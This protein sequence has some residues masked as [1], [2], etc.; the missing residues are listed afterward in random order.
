MLESLTAARHSLF[1]GTIVN[2]E[3]LNTK[4]ERAVSVVPAMVDT[5]ARGKRDGDGEEDAES[6]ASDPTELFHRDIG[7]QT[8]PDIDTSESAEEAATVAPVEEHSEKLSSIRRHLGDLSGTGQESLEA[9]EETRSSLGNLQAYLEELAYGGAKGA[10][11][12]EGGFGPL[13]EPMSSAAPGRGGA[14]SMDEIARFKADIRSVK[15]VLLSA[16]NFPTG[17]L[18]RGWG[19]V[20]VAS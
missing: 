19:G 2:L 10:L 17:G 3:T 14:G 18:G 6:E 15:G 1:E 5:Q 16:R 12:F 20:G 13:G 8:S 4:L 7:V 11:H 9:A